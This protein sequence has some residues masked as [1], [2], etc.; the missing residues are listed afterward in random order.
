MRKA[1]KE[2]KRSKEY[3]L[4]FEKQNSVFIG[5]WSS[6]SAVKKKLMPIVY[7]KVGKHLWTCIEYQ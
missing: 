7:Q 3:K 6:G 5:I 4:H 1:N 2:I